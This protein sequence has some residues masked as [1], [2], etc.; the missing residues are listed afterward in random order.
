MTA[1][2]SENL[3]PKPAVWHFCLESASLCWPQH[4][5]ISDFWSII[6]LNYSVFILSF[7][8]LHIDPASS[9]IVSCRLVGGHVPSIFAVQYTYYFEF[10]MVMPEQSFLRSNALCKIYLSMACHVIP[11]ASRPLA[12]HFSCCQKRLRK[13][14]IQLEW[15]VL[16]LNSSC[17]HKA[18]S[19][20]I[21]PS[22]GVQGALTLYISLAKWH[23]RAVSISSSSGPWVLGDRCSHHN[24]CWS[25]ATWMLSEQ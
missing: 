18:T 19:P 3:A 6:L 16:Q 17:Q 5:Q 4:I 1:S 11:A 22:A 21:Q 20:Q 15:E 2:A 12:H 13:T 7:S 14:W 24:P 8:I 25:E 10:P 9:T 23:A